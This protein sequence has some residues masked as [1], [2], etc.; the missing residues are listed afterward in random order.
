MFTLSNFLSFIRV[1]LAL[2]FLQKNIVVRLIATILAM[3]SDSVDG[4]FARKNKSISKFGA[5]FDPAMD[6]FFV[7]FVLFILFFENDIKLWQVCTLLSRDFALII[8]GFYALILRKWDFFE[9]R[10]IRWGKVTTAM[11]FVVI[12]F[13]TAKFNLSWYIYILFVILGILAF[14]ELIYKKPQK[15]SKIKI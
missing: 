1:P 8:Y 14:I 12:I 7:Y 4:Y 2:V 6:K 3:I 9:F 5:I 13:V 15:H 10:S 11:Q